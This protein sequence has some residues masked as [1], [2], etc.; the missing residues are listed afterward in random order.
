MPHPDFA[1]AAA[2]ITADGVR[3]CLAD[4]VNISSPTGSE[5]GVAQYLVERM[6]KSGLETDL[7]LVDQGR[8]NA[9]GH[10][11]GRG[12]PQSPVQLLHDTPTRDENISRAMGSGPRPRF[13]TAGCLVSAPTI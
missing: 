13:A 7:P 12:D 2:C 8:P 9:V 5:I 4:L 10:L 1:K 3:D 6:R 11:R